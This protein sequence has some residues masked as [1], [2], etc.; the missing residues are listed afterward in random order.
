MRLTSLLLPVGVFATGLYAYSVLF[1]CNHCSALA[2]IAPVA[3]PSFVD[4]RR[5]IVSAPQPRPLQISPSSEGASAAPTGVAGRA[6]PLIAPSPAATAQV[7]V[8]PLPVRWNASSRPHPSQIRLP[9]RKVAFAVP[10][11]A[12][13]SPA[14]GHAPRD[15]PLITGSIGEQPQAVRTNFASPPDLPT[16][17]SERADMPT[18]G[19]GVDRASPEPSSQSAPTSTARIIDRSLRSSLGGPLPPPQPARLRSP[20]HSHAQVAVAALPV[21]PPLRNPLR[22]APRR[23]WV[24]A[25]QAPVP[26][27]AAGRPS[28]AFPPPSTSRASIAGLPKP[29]QA[30]PRPSMAAPRLA[31]LATREAGPAST[32]PVP[33]QRPAARAV[34]AARSASSASAGAPSAQLRNTKIRRSVSRRPKIRRVR[35]KAASRKTRRASYRNY[36]AWRNRTIARQ[37]RRNRQFRHSRYRRVRPGTVFGIY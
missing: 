29:P 3:A 17:E 37:I 14:A 5:V 20:A 28:Q 15:T 4:A 16:G 32:T 25:V 18:D 27:R 2:R 24:P 23:P 31:R 19:R 10:R 9:V 35:Q 33:V 11:P 1:S 8:V 36:Q 12:P 22:W 7:A 21:A 30:G 6:A 34:L 26:V 13:P